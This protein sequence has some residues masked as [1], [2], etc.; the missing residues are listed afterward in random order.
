MIEPE[1]KEKSMAD[2]G[3]ATAFLEEYRWSSY[4]D[5]SGKYNFPSITDSEI[6]GRVFENPGIVKKFVDSWIGCKCKAVNS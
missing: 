1:W 4:P 6:F 5:N 3:R 2:S